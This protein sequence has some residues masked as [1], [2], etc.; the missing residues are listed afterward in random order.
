MN[1]CLP[2]CFPTRSGGVELDSPRL[3][4]PP[5]FW[6][7]TV[8]QPRLKCQL[9][10]W[11]NYLL[12]WQRSAS[13]WLKQLERNDWQLHF[14]TELCDRVSS[15]HDSY[16]WDG[17]PLLLL[18]GCIQLGTM[19]KSQGN[20]HNGR[21][22]WLLSKNLIRID[23]FLVPMLRNL[24]RQWPMRSPS[25]TWSPERFPTFDPFEQR[26]QEAGLIHFLSGMYDSV[27]YLW[28]ESEMVYAIYQ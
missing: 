27:W 20:L 25:A 2:W 26:V 8:K 28:Y 14:E 5:D 18:L 10:I 4:E 21:G 3:G 1:W 13:I 11:R 22:V 23:A 9:Q 19:P 24:I 15:R 7:P 12:L 6:V 17:Y 16:V